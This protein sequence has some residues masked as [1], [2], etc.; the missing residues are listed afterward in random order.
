MKFAYHKSSQLWFQL[1][2]LRLPWPILG[3]RNS[4]LQKRLPSQW[5]S[6]SV[7][8]ILVW[9]W[10]RHAASHN[11][12]SICASATSYDSDKSFGWG[13][14]LLLDISLPE[15]IIAQMAL[16][17]LEASAERE[18]ESWRKFKIPAS[19]SWRRFPK[20]RTNPLFSFRGSQMQYI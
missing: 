13:E 12:H 16:W 1:Q 17:R 8:R 3:N 4:F 18:R 19:E 11:P 5:I 15:R 9:T 6:I 10:Y 2:G 20:V 7:D 14:P